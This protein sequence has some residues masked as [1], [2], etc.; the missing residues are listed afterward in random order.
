MFLDDTA[1]NLASINLVQFCDIEADGK[2]FDIQ[3]YKH[4]IRLWMMTLEIAVKMCQAPSKE[5][6][7]G[8]YK[9]RTTGLGY[10]N[11]G[12]LL[13][14]LGIPYDSDEGRA[15]GGALASIMTGYSYATSAEMAAEQGPFVRFEANKSSMMRV[16]KNHRTAAYGKTSG[17]D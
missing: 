9:Y 15:I 14:G 17:Y 12:G 11:L 5:I 7:D 3:A 1:C 16:M 2:N 8:T 4:A 6:A 10:A 13:M